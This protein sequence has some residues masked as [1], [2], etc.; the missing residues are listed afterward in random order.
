MEERPIPPITPDEI[1]DPAAYERV[2]E[3]RRSTVLRQRRLLTLDVGETLSLS[4]ETRPNVLYRIQEALRSEWPATPER[5]DQTIA[6]LSR[7]LPQ[8]REPAGTLLIHPV[9]L[10]H[11]ASE[12]A[13]FEGL[14]RGGHVFLELGQNQRAA[15]VFPR[16]RG[17]APVTRRAWPVRFP[18]SPEAFSRFLDAR[19]PVH[20]VIG[21]PACRGRVEVPEEMRR[22]LGQESRGS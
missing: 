2:R 10:A 14:D 6:R 7:F 13:P 1:L 8:P 4:F 19:Q 16:A 5:I 12:L 20:F 9:D 22:T 17:H 18:M 21:H 11:L 15:A 3:E